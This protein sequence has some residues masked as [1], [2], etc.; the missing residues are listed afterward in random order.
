MPRRGGVH[1]FLTSALAVVHGGSVAVRLLARGGSMLQT[2]CAGPLDGDLASVSPAVTISLG[3]LMHGR[4]S[5]NFSGT[6]AFAV[7]GF[8]GTISSTLVVALG[9]PSV[10][11]ASSGADFP[12][13]ISTQRTRIVTERLDPVRVAG[14]LSAAVRG[15]SDPVECALL[16]TCGLSGTLTLIPQA[17]EVTGNVLAMGPADR[18]YRDFLTAMGL[19]RGGRSRGITVAVYVNVNGDVRAAI[20]QAGASC[21]DTGATGGISAVV[22]PSGPSPGAGFGPSWRTRCPGPLLADKTTGVAASLPA[23]ALTHRRFTIRLRSNGSLTDDGYFITPQGAISVLVRRGRV[24]SQVTT[25][26]AR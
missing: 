6:R 23:G 9:R 4:T 25:F 12:P 8:A 26:P 7:H 21:V 13:G 17:R 19:A 22:E 11:P 16:D 15:A 18:P 14:G 5:L 24:R 2:R 10:Q 3:R 1:P 20:S